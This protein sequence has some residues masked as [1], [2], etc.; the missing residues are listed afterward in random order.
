MHR[1]EFLNTFV[2]C[3]LLQP[4]TDIGLTK[5]LNCVTVSVWLQKILQS[6]NQANTD[7]TSTI[8]T[9]CGYTDYFSASQ[10]DTVLGCSC[11]GCSTPE[12]I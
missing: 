12:H 3:L 11:Y 9:A 6:C 10:V 5:K 2:N 1:K 4:F 8:D 7:S